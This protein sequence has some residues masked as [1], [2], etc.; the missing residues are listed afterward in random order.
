MPRKVKP[1]KV[2]HRHS[3]G[4]SVMDGNGHPTALT[5]ERQAALLR[6]LEVGDWPAM[7]AIRAEC[8]PRTVVSWLER[9]LEPAAV[10]PY[11]SFALE[12]VKVEAR[13][14]GQLTAVIMDHALGRG[15]PKK[16]SRNADPVWAWK[17]LESR[18]RFLWRIDGQG[19]AG[20]QSVTE[21]VLAAVDKLDAARAEKAREYVKQ[22][23]PLVKEQARKEGFQL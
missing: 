11:A 22:L 6:E 23:P 7:A 1:P 20:G 12:F 15:K 9:G 16:G 13:L 18:F 21:L 3:V 5:P 19:N 17:M 4:S 14:C 10:E 8:S 2:P